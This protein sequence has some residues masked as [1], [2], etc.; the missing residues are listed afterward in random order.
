MLFT[1]PN[2]RLGWDPQTA[3]ETGSCPLENDGEGGR[4]G[5]GVVEEKDI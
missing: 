4:G 1:S 3:R 5:G 2:K